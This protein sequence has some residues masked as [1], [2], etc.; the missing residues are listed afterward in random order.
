MASPQV[1]AEPVVDKQPEDDL[2]EVVDDAAEVKE[3]KV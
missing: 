3:G 2:F 1:E